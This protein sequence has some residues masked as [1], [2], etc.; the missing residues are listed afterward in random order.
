MENSFALTPSHERGSK[1]NSFSGLPL[2]AEHALS[3]PTIRRIRMCVHAIKY[4]CNQ[5][6]Q[7]WYNMLRYIAYLIRKKKSN[8]LLY[9]VSVQ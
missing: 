1:I 2:R 4:R 8:I 7:L 3:L 6:L 9:A 5:P